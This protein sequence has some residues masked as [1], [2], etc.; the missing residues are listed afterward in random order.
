M[1]YGLAAGLVHRDSVV[2][3]VY[4]RLSTPT[5]THLT[6]EKFRLWRA[7]ADRGSWA[8]IAKIC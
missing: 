5:E 7:I 8:A 3:A 1:F 4:D 2:T 6:G